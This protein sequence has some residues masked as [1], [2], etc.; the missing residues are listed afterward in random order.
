MAY[1]IV[2]FTSVFVFVF[3]WLTFIF[4]TH[5]YTRFLGM[6]FKL[7]IFWVTVGIFLLALSNS[8]LFLNP[9][10]WRYSADVTTLVTAVFSTI[11][12]LAF[13][14]SAGYLYNFS[15]IYGF[16]QKLSG[17]KFGRNVKVVQIKAKKKRQGRKRKLS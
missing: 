1:E 16:A 7:I 12:A 13:I 14:I 8:Y 9:Y 17:R 15:K 6:E 4:F 3:T 11:S 2:S 10:L 5:S